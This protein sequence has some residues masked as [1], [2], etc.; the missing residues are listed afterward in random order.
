MLHE[1]NQSRAMKLEKIALPITLSKW[2]RKPTLLKNKQ[3]TGVSINCNKND[4]KSTENQHVRRICPQNRWKYNM[5][6]TIL[7]LILL[8]AK[9]KKIIEERTN[10]S[11]VKKKLTMCII[12]HPQKENQSDRRKQI[13][14][15]LTQG[16]IPE[17]KMEKT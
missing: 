9:I 11:K 2:L 1:N 16:N 5:I 7:R 15:I 3:Q 14:S 17:I 8:N 6:Y 10:K 4:Y 12:A 13:Q